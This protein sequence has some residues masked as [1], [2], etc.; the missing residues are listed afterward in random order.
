MEDE[1]SFYNNKGSLTNRM[2]SIGEAFR[3]KFKKRPIVTN[4]MQFIKKR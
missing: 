3:L 2:V 1:I 4:A